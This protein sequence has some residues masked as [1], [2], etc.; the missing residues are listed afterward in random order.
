ME[1]SNMKKILVTGSSGYIGSH[2][3]KMLQN[4]YI[5]HGLDIKNPI[6]D[7]DRFY[8]I[9]VRDKFTI[10]ESYD[11]VIHLAA[12][13]NVG[14]SQK[15][16]ISYY[17]TNVLGTINTFDIQT[18]NYIL[19]STG[20]AVTKQSH[21]GLGKYVAEECTKQYMNKHHVDYTIFRF[22]NV[23]GSDGINPTNVDGLMYN[24]YKAPSR[25]WFVIYGNDYDT[26]DG[27]CVRDYVHVNE[28]CNA[29]HKAIDD[30]SKQIENLGHGVGKSVREIVDCFRL[31][32][33]VQ[34]HIQYAYRRKGDVAISVLDTP[35]RYMEKLYTFEELINYGSIYINKI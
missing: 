35:S 13:V 8:N 22:Y 34:F 14:E 15:D 31:V 24:L 19:A 28:I 2:L 12:L 29:L 11:A 33:D 23:I 16:P 18:D 30:P 25:G 32:N 6:I 20:A 1:Q 21:Y 7:V 4:K 17:K 3:C 10:P 9:D 5:V 26:I 27:T